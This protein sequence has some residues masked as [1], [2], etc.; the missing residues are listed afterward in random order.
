M[1]NCFLAT[2]EFLV[3]LEVTDRV[4]LSLSTP[5]ALKPGQLPIT[6]AISCASIV[7]LSGYFESYLKDTVREYISEINN[8]GKPI[9]LIPYGMKVKHYA[10]GAEALLWAS[11]KDKNLKTTSMSLDLTR[12]LGSLHNDVGYELAWESFANT[13]SNPGKDTVHAILVG[14]EVEK[15]W[16]EINGL[17]KQHGRLDTF[18]ESFIQMRNVCA[19]TGRHHTP[20]T[21]SDIAGYVECFRALAE[22]IDLLI[23]I[24]L[25]EFRK[26]TA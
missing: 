10:G 2:D 23:G 14:L 26:A 24:R 9:A 5:E 18:L 4:A 1:E 17:K 11:K 20:P 21:A 22:C 6:N 12:R 19:H 16:A 15:A 8:L 7:L 13:K 25:E 3:S